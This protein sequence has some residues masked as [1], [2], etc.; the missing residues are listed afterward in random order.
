M[1]QLVV[2]LS[3][4]KRITAASTA[5]QHIDCHAAGMAGAGHCGGIRRNIRKVF[6]LKGFTLWL[7][8]WDTGTH[9]EKRNNQTRGK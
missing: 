2:S 6:A 4:D 8:K 7:G 9:V 5:E 3:S 1:K